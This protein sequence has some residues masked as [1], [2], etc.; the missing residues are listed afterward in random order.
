MPLLHKIAAVVIVAAVVAGLWLPGERDGSR[1]ATQAKEPVAQAGGVGHRSPPPAPGP[2]PGKA[3]PSP[4]GTVGPATPAAAAAKANELGQVPVIMYHRI[5]P[6]PE[7]DLDRSAKDFR[8]ELVRLAK[9][10]YVPITAGEFAAGWINVPA[11]RHPVVLTFDDSMPEQFS[12]DAQGRPK[13]GT[14]V[15]IIQEVARRYPGFR[16]TATFYLTKDL[17]RLDGQEAAGLAWLLRN[18]FELGNHT[19]S[20]RNLSQL[21]KKDVQREIGDIE[22]RIVRLTGRHTTTLAY[23][24]GAEPDKRSWAAKKDGAYA[25]KGVFLAGWKPS[26]SPFD[27]DFDPLAIT[28]VQS[29]GK[30][31]RNDCARYC[32]AAWLDEL[33]RNPE[34]RYTSDGDPNTIT[35]PRAAEDRLAK[36]LRGR[37]RVY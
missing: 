30:I 36:E 21:S 18:G 12:L 11:G 19:L 13:A 14:A 34:S 28:R 27:K 22:A 9:S 8:A 10:G 16:P 29:E 5:V 20:H 15:A 37:G 35:F 3:A 7:R 33:E 17:F 1:A 32:S 2:A 25:F 26:E 31:D 4:A 24:F 6:K 23:P